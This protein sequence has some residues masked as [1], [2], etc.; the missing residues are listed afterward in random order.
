ML[1]KMSKNTVGQQGESSEHS[2]RSEHK[3]KLAFKQL[4]V[5]ETSVVWLQ[6]DLERTVLEES[7]SRGQINHC[8][9]Y[10]FYCQVLFYLYK[11]G[12]RTFF[13]DLCQFPRFTL[14]LYCTADLQMCTS[15]ELESFIVSFNVNFFHY[16][17]KPVIS[18]FICCNLNFIIL[19]HF[20]QPLEDRLDD[21]VIEKS[22][23]TKKATLTRFPPDFEPIP[24]RPLFFDLALNHVQFPSLD[25]KLDQQK[26]AAGAGG[27]GLTGIVKGW[28]WGGGKK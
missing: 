15:Y 8:F 25:D 28:L 27:G 12:A 11:H 9:N 5:S 4:L 13:T 14:F 10:Y 16:I 17:W 1:H 20:K 24:C 3:T 6:V 2:A 7:G 23:T 21:Y 18:W 19:F 26:K 22:L